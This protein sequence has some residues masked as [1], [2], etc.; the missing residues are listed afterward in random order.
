M[1]FSLLL[2]HIHGA[3]WKSS[4]KRVR[5]G[6][7]VVLAH[8]FL[9]TM[10]VVADP[11]PNPSWGNSAKQSA[12]SEPTLGQKAGDSATSAGR[13][14]S[15]ASQ[16]S[17]DLV[18]PQPYSRKQLRALVRN[19]RTADDHAALATYF[20]TREREFRTKE[21]AQQELLRE[22]LKGHTKY[23]SKYPTRGDTAR[24][25]ASYYSLQA[26]KASSLALEHEKSAT[27][28]RPRK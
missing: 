28:L 1:P 11:T 8:T 6:L 13:S 22:Y 7:V 27:E 25:L 5:K 20:R 10:M 16:S 3:M 21:A 17:A 14:D 12:V 15:S 18:R 19:V 9:T 26:Q 2:R 4:G 24:D 23:P